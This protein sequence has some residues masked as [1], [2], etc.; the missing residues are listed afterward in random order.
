[1]RPCAIQAKLVVS[2]PAD[3]GEEGGIGTQDADKSSDEHDLAAVAPEQIPAHGKPPSGQMHVAAVAFHQPRTAEVTRGVAN[4]VPEDRGAGGDHGDHDDV[5]PVRRSGVQ[6]G[7]DQGGLTWQRN[8][9][10]FQPDQHSYGEIPIGVKEAHNERRDHGRAPQRID[11]Q[12]TRPYAGLPFRSLSPRPVPLA[13]LSQVMAIPV[14]GG[15]DLRAGRACLGR[16]S[17]PPWR[18]GA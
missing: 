2:H 11:D 5:E 10:A 6:R 14:L 1:M 4:V 8:P 9:D 16:L 15:L 17:A 3:P 13:G 18:M 12:L 7:R